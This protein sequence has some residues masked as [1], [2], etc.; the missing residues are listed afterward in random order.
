M[1]TYETPPPMAVGMRGFGGLVVGN[2]AVDDSG[3][4]P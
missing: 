1:S 2:Y 4:A 3:S